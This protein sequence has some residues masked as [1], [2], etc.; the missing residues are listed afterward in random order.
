MP[1]AP[2]SQTMGAYLSYGITHEDRNNYIELFHMTKKNKN[3]KRL[4]KRKQKQS[5]GIVEQIVRLGTDKLQTYG[6]FKDTVDYL[7]DKRNSITSKITENSAIVTSKV[8]LDAMRS[9]ADDPEKWKVFGNGSEE[10]RK[11]LKKL[12]R[13][14]FSNE[15]IVQRSKIYYNDATR[16]FM[17][18]MNQ[19]ASRP[20]AEVV[21]NIAMHN[22]DEFKELVNVSEGLSYKTFEEHLKS[23]F[24]DD[25]DLTEC[26]YFGAVDGESPPHDV[27]SF[28]MPEVN[29]HNHEDDKIDLVCYSL[30]EIQ[31]Y[32]KEQKASGVKKIP[33]YL[34]HEIKKKLPKADL[35][36]YM[37]A[38]WVQAVEH[39]PTMEQGDIV[40]MSVVRML[41]NYAIKHVAY[42]K[43]ILSYTESLRQK[44]ANITPQWIKNMLHRGKINMIYFM[45]SP[46]VMQTAVLISKFMRLVCC[47]WISTW[48]SINPALTF[49]NISKVLVEMAE[50][51]AKS[52]PLFAIPYVW[53]KCIYNS[54]G[55]I[56]KLMNFNVFGAIIEIAK[57]IYYGSDAIISTFG[58]AGIMAYAMPF[59]IITG[60][61]TK[62]LEEVWGNKEGELQN[63]GNTLMEKITGKQNVFGEIAT[64]LN[65]VKQLNDDTWFIG[66]KAHFH[67]WLTMTMISI[68]PSSIVIA[69]MTLFAGMLGPTMLTAYVMMNNFVQ[70]F[71]PGQNVILVMWTWAHRGS[72]MVYD[73]YPFK[74]IKHLFFFFKEMYYWI[75]EVGKCGMMKIYNDYIAMYVDKDYDPSKVISYERCCMAEQVEKI[76]SIVKTEA[77]NRQRE[78]D[79]KAEEER[80][81]NK[82]KATEEAAKQEEAKDRLTSEIVVRKYEDAANDLSKNEYTRDEMMQEIEEINQ[83]LLVLPEDDKSRKQYEQRLVYL[84]TEISKINTKIENLSKTVK[85]TSD[86]I[87]STMK[88]KLSNLLLKIKTQVALCNE[89]GID[90]EKAFEFIVSDDEKK[91]TDK[92]RSKI[93]KIIKSTNVS[94][95]DFENGVPQEF[96]EFQ[97]DLKM[98]TI[99]KDMVQFAM[100]EL[101]NRASKMIDDVKKKADTLKTEEMRRKKTL[102]ITKDSQK[103]WDNYVALIPVLTSVNGFFST[104]QHRDK[105]KKSM[106]EYIR[107]INFAKTSVGKKTGYEPGWLT[108]KFRKQRK[109]NTQRAQRRKD[110]KGESPDKGGKISRKIMFKQRRKTR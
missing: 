103:L 82:T 23:E 15:M 55:I 79:E 50:P 110:K 102:E 37:S 104:F 61:D 10:G 83:K 52:N 54:S 30:K 62:G 13:S 65:L 69:A 98:L 95:I 6:M 26:H 89:K 90:C 63:F 57:V 44:V 105:T 53:L 75:T 76:Q 71:Y 31:L 40:I 73:I 86:S 93:D 88:T 87:N 27:A 16:T 91:N 56:D 35:Q 29:E 9:I 38:M 94:Y 17:D 3:K 7:K 49:Y 80:I 19:V 106:V 68:M 36:E 72:G 74:E 46:R 70:L 1:L 34:Y 51:L 11:D 84:Q 21:H 28:C 4:S 64:G 25:R 109:T 99:E 108:N 78:K 96:Q 81:A 39:Y 43:E 2:R 5:G 41:Y 101:V 12:L 14:G 48:G 24:K 97:D 33:T 45:K 92:L 77:I 32:V 107:K 67:E 58:F 42:L 59:K 8:N 47:V 22:F 85:T 60:Y 18:A 20:I 100:E 66:F